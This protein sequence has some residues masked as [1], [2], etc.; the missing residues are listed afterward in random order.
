LRVLAA[1]LV[2]LASASNALAN[3]CRSDFER[4]VALSESR[5][6]VQ[7]Q[8]NVACLPS[9]AVRQELLS[10]LARAA[11]KCQPD[12]NTQHTRTM[13][14]I[15]EGFVGSLPVCRAEEP[16]AQTA[17]TPSSPP[18]PPKPS[19]PCLEM[20]R[21]TPERY[22]LSN[23]HCA[24]SKILAIVEIRKATGEIACKGHTIEKR[25]VLATESALR[26]Q[27]NYDCPLNGA[28]C[29]KELV[30]KMFPECDW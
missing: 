30:S 15:N 5:L 6:R 27:L 3:E 29:T 9:E 11:A 10:A 2:V 14:T 19:R 20:S 7:Q 23:R 24:D 22:V 21:L 1:A 28:R 25:L 17:K 26:P 16:P 13:I 8:A 4:W 12:Q 18:Q